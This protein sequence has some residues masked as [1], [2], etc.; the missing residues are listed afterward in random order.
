MNEE[1]TDDIIVDFQSVTKY[2]IG[3]F[4]A[5]YISFVE[6]DY[7]NIVNYYNGSTSIIP[8]DSFAFLSYLI[9]EQKNIIDIIILNA[10]VLDNYGYWILVE[11]IEDI[12][13]ALETASNASKWMRSNLTRDGYKNSVAVE[14][15]MSQGQGLEQVERDN[16]KSNDADGWIN[17]ALENQLREEDYDLNGGTLIKVIFKNN[18]SIVLNSVVD[19]I[20][21]KEK[22]YGKDIDKRL[23]FEND[24]LVTLSYNDTLLQSAKILAD[25]KR[26]DDPAFPDRGLDVRNVLGGSL[27]GISYPTIFRQL[28]ENFSTDDSF[29]SFSIT[30]I[31]RDRDAIILKF[32]V[33]TRTGEV[34][35]N[36]IPLNG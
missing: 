25:L 9:D 18:A 14:F 4:L 13:S 12:G 3:Q 17:T 6:T 27:A 7:G 31:A 20:D 16:L 36:L 33:E 34:F 1:L 24:D 22:T 26:G 15:V 11:K 2:D 5:D 21:T 29:K 35:E 23:V 8:K 28:A 32:Q 30:D 19:N 10:S